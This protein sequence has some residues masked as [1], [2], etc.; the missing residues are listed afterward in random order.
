MPR[1][2]GPLLQAAVRELSDVGITTARL[3]AR[4]LL[5]EA[6][7]LRHE[8]II[9]DPSR[10][11]SGEAAER[12]RVWLERRLRHEPVSRILGRR[13]FY[14]R[15]FRVTKDTL[16]PR[17][18]TETLVEAALSLVPAGQRRNVLD[19]GTGTGAIIV[20]LLA[21]RP[22]L[23]GVATDVSRDA[24][25]VARS[26]AEE[27]DVSDRLVL[28]QGSWFDAVEGQFDVIVSNPPYIPDADIAGLGA[29]VRAHDPM[30]ALTGGA[31]GLDAYRSIAS[32]ASAH[33]VTG[34]RICV[35]I[36]QGQ[37]HDVKR[38]FAGRGFT[39]VSEIHDLAGIVRVLILALP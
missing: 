18:D 3:D 28:K 27:L 25:Q 13:E 31:D 26:N 17:P 20:T 8:D 19:L 10:M 2:I 9:A 1:E 4:L 34:G 39:C 24:L 7:G 11:I 29:E 32:G 30:L 12:F 36:G 22:L 21:E 14:G 38:I 6:A 23:R 33:L 35:E 15:S 37:S 5:Q 16:D